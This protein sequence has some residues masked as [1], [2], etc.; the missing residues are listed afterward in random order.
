MA[1]VGRAS[2]QLPV[3]YAYD[4]VDFLAGTPRYRKSTVVSRKNSKTDVAGTQ[5]GVW[6]FAY[7]VATDELPVTNENGWI[8]HS[9]NV[10]PPVR[11]Q[12]NITTVTDPKGNAK[13]HYHFGYHSVRQAPTAVGSYLGSS[14]SSENIL[15]AYQNFVI[16]SQID[17]VA[18]KFTPNNFNPVARVLRKQNHYR[19]GESFSLEKSN[20][21]SYGNAGTVLETGS[22]HADRTYSRVSALAYSVD[23]GKWLLNQVAS[24]SVTSS[25]QTH[26]TNRQ[27]DGSGNVLSETVAGVTSTATY[28][29][30]GDVASKTNALGQTASFANY[31]R[32]I[33]RQENHPENVTI[34]RGVDNAGNITSETNGRGKTTAF[35][36]DSLN[37][38]TSIARPVGAVTSVSWTP[39]TRT[40]K[41]G[42][43][44]DVLT[45]D[46]LGRTVRRQVSAPG[47]TSVWVNYTRNILGELVHQSYPN[48]SLGTGYEYDELGRVIATLNGNQAGTNSARHINYTGYH[49]LLVSNQDS[50]GRASLDFYRAYSDPNKRER[51]RLAAGEP[52]NGALS[53]MSDVQQ[54]RD[55]LGQLTSVSMNGRTRSYGYDSR[56]FLVSKTDPEIGNTTFERD[57]IGNLT[58]KSVGAGPATSYAYDGRNRLT[59]IVYPASEDPSV[60]LAPAVSSTYDR[61]DNLI[62]SA[63]GNVAHS[64]S[65]DDNDNLTQES[66]TLGSRIQTLRYAYN[67]NEALASVTYPSG[68]QVNYNPDAFGRARTALPYVS[69]VSYH[70]NGMPGQISYA[71]GVVS[72]LSIN[73]RHW[74]SALQYGKGLSKFVNSAYVYDPLGNL[75]NV[76]EYAD[77]IYARAFAYDKLDRLVTEVTT[78]GTREYY[79]DGMGNLRYLLTPSTLNTYA[80]DPGTGLLDGVS[81]GFFRAF[82]YDQAGNVSANGY[83]SFGHDRANNMRCVDCGLA[84]QKLHTYDSANMRVQTVDGTGTTQYLH[85]KQ[86][87]LMQ[88]LEPGVRK[89]H[90]YLGRRQVAERRID[91]N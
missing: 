73:D 72:S 82:E 18:Q 81:G 48:S 87:L 41:R 20:F 60:P 77:G 91:L 8:T 5:S 50:T 76:N 51:V 16:S 38:V 30:T 58:S 49:S 66:L 54:T 42:N 3:D 31:H 7:Q 65:Y 57:A 32:G 25:G 29:P 59:S 37:R 71:N 86:G 61:N 45:S 40:V 78:G 33:A 27:F 46:G 89:E 84:T 28:H 15:L 64:Y 44:T 22:N 53:V 43:M 74:P 62:S 39:T 56:Y 83:N 79:Y 63:S 13:E 2:W 35:S 88:T 10:P 70:P 52:V 6:T 67:N 55:I 11:N 21:D 80:Y 12:V 90:I 23:T 19:I 26:T 68:N 24:Q 34:T 1:G 14:S 85:S 17:V 69:S 9:Y 36:Y 4:H 47:E 75:A